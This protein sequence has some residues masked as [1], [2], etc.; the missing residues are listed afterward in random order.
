MYVTGQGHRVIHSRSVVFLDPP[1]RQSPTNSSI[2]KDPLRIE[3]DAI[4]TDT[5]QKDEDQCK[6]EVSSKNLG[7]PLNPAQVNDYNGN[8]E[9]TQ[10][11]RSERI[12]SRSIGLFLVLLKQAHMLTRQE[13][14]TP[15]HG[16]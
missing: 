14:L 6:E 5:T 4:T 1:S 16:P 13:G 15:N 8:P 7:P 10:R 12:S 2:Q 11:R 3:G 9:L